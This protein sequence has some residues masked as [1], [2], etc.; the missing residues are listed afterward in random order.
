MGL[1]SLH[2]PQLIQ[3]YYQCPL[4]EGHWAYNNLVFAYSAGRGNADGRFP[5]NYGAFVGNV[6]RGASERGRTIVPANSTSYINFPHLADYNILGEISIVAL[7]RPTSALAQQAIV[8]KCETSG[9]ANTPFGFFVDNLKVSLNRSNAGFRVWAGTVNVT[10]DTNTVIAATQGSNISV[11]PKFYINGVFD[12]GAAS[13]LYGGS[14]TGAPTGNT[15]SIKI[16]NRTD[17]LSQCFHGIYDVLIFNRVLSAAEIAE[18]SRNIWAVWEAPSYDIFIA[19]GANSYTL[20]PSGGVVFSGSAELLKTK[21]FLPTGNLTLAGTSA[22]VKTKVLS[23]VGGVSLS[24]DVPVVKTKVVT[25][26]GGLSFT[27]TSLLIKTKILDA[28]GTIT[29]SGTASLSGAMTYII[30]PVGGVTLSGTAALVKTR[31]QIPTGRITFSGSAPMESNTVV[32]VTSSR[33]PL[34]GAGS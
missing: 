30:T 2:Q 5:S 19:G 1:L 22:L 6:S 29:F 11:A 23:P 28:G 20:S 27:G 18:L 10:S 17:L 7:I 9:G 15:T 33:L 14:G 25:P 26:T 13:N 3:P 21:I 12:S 8:T 32:S 4:D 16:G 24:G 31:V 34:T